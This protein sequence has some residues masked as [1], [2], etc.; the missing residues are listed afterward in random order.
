MADLRMEVTSKGFYIEPL[1][2]EGLDFVN[3]DGYEP[4]YQIGDHV[5]YPMI[6]QDVLIHEAQHEGLVIEA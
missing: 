5:D 1:T 6:A 3:G 2:I 4:Q